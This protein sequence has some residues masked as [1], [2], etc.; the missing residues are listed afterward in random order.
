MFDAVSAL[1]N[2]CPESRFHAEA[3]MRLEAAIDK[4][5]PDTYSFYTGDTISFKPTI[6]QI[7]ND[8][9]NN[10]PLHK[11]STKFHNTVIEVILQTIAKISRQHN[12]KK[13]ALSG[14]TFQNKFITENIEQKLTQKGYTVYSQSKIPANDGGI[15]LGQLIIAA[16]R[17][18]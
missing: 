18:R 15:A 9:K 3:P 2:L 5:I 10:T 1:V 6:E 17:K 14:G 13:V 16:N 11:I 7:V 4:T 8:I 12:I